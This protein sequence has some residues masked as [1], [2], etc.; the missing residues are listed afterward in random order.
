[1]C[2]HAAFCYA[3]PDDETFLSGCLIRMLADCSHPPA[4]LL[5]TRGDAGNKNGAYSQLSREELGKLAWERGT[6]GPDK[7]EENARKDLKL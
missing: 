3:H 1:M 6:F 2:A 5:A 4:L 7:S